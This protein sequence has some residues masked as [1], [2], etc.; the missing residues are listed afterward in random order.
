MHFRKHSGRSRPLFSGPE[1]SQGYLGFAPAQ[2]DLTIQQ[3]ADWDGLSI[4]Q[5]RM[6]L[7]SCADSRHRIS[8][9]GCGKA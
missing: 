6:T 8:I 5:E 7:R 3:T 4:I 9:A 1:R 2:A